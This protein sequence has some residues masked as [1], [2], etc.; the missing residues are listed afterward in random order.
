MEMGSVIA[1]WK[2]AISALSAGWAAAPTASAAR[3]AEAMRV[4]PISRT[5]GTEASMPETVRN[6]I[7]NV[8]MR[9]KI[10]S[11]V[12]RLRALRLFSTEMSARTIIA[13][14]KARRTA[15]ATQPVNSGMM[16]GAKRSQT[17]SRAGVSRAARTTPIARKA[18]RVGRFRRFTTMSS[19]SLA[20]R[21]AMRWR[22]R[23]SKAWARKA[24]VRP[25][26][27]AISAINGRSAQSGKPPSRLSM[28]S[29]MG[30]KLCCIAAVS[31]I[32]SL[33]RAF[34]AGRRR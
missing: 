19:A 12:R 16:K 29:I 1:I 34:G 24:S 22:P 7:R 20:L 6:T 11:R 32:G 3:P 5:P 15:T 21:C 10:D 31:A 14:T 26:S 9:L 2:P 30:L 8:P 17:A 18:Q 28:K 27:A 4:T 23:N 25:I 13:S 33:H